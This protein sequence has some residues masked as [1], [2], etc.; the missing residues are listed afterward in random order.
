MSVPPV[1]G[2]PMVALSTV[3]G[4]EDAERIAGALVERGLAA[5]V[6]IVPGV[7]SVYRWQGR[8]ER[9]QEHL[10][11]MKTSAARFEELKRHLLEL[12]P[13][14]VPELVAWPLGAGH[15][16]YLDWLDESLR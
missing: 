12:H 7:T 5:C 8:V 4:R 10:L 3:G 11:V 15:R 9:D 6:N 2:E 13:Y 16:A 14:E 1:V